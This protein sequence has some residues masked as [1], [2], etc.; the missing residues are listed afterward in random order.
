MEAFFWYLAKA[1]LVW[2]I[3]FIA[4]YLLLRKEQAFQLNRFLLW[5]IV[6]LSFGLPLLPTSIPTAELLPE[7]EIARTQ[8]LEGTTALTEV[9]PSKSIT[10]SNDLI[11][12]DSAILIYGN[13]LLSLFWGIY[14]LGILYFLGQTIS[15]VYKTCRLIESSSKQSLGGYIF[16]QHIYSIEPFSFFHFIVLN[17]GLISAGSRE[18]VITHEKIHAQQWHTLDILM[19]NLVHAIFWMNP[20]VWLWRNQLKLQLEFFTDRAV[21]HTG[22]DRKAYQYSI[23]KMGQGSTQSLPANLFNTSP[24]KNRISMMNTKQSPAFRLLKYFL[25]LPLIGITCAFVQPSAVELSL[26]DFPSL[27]D[28]DFKSVYVAITPDLEEKLLNEIVE[29]LRAIGIFFDVKNK[30]YNDEKLTSIDLDIRVPGK[31]EANVKSS[32]DNGD[33][34]TI[35]FYYE[36]SRKGK[37][38]VTK[39]FPDE[40][41]KKGKRIFK[42]Q[43]HMGVYILRSDGGGRMIGAMTIDNDF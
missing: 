42:K 17:P 1:H 38:G 13:V 20:L 3:L 10:A 43:L 9:S 8:L 11:E 4:F 35:Y 39:E 7:L 40:I 21:L 16:V 14:G 6:L 28:N 5:S 41:S 34:E 12:R 15:G 19:G 36:K 25:F 31:M 22:V 30:N 2:M 24:I 37:I 29:E 26:N 27:G 18:Q 23:L 32:S 33:F